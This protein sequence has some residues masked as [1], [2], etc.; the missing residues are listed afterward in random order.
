MM[1]LLF[2]SELRPGIDMA[3]YQA[4]RARMMDLVAKIDGF[5]SY[6]TYTAGDGETIAIARFATEDAL[7]AWRHHPEHVAVQ[8]RG[9]AEFY[10]SYSIQA[11]K[12]V[13]D[14]AW[15]RP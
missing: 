7:D 3:E 13:R 10:E 4:T 11:L 14:Y 12:S 5:I 1:V 15:E 2:T 8:R 6:K 9:Q